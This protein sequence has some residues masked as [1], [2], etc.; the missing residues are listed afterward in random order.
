MALP[1]VL[2]KAKNMVSKGAQAAKTAGAVRSATSNSNDEEVKSF[3]GIFKTPIII[4][5]AI[6]GTIL[7]FILVVFIAIVSIPQ[8]LVGTIFGGGS[9]SSNINGGTNGNY[10]GDIGYIQ[11]AIDIANDDSHGYSQ[12]ARTAPDYDCSS[13]VY[14][15]LINAG[16]TTEQLGSYPFTT[17][18]MPTVLPQ[19]GFVRHSFVQ[20]ELQAG[21]ILW[22]SGHTAMYIGNDQIVHASGPEGGGLCGSA[23]DQTGKEIL[24]QGIAG[25]GPWTAY[26]RRA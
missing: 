24:V 26:Y 10:S 5:S 16:F 11:W 13:L 14:Y 17:A 18:T 21:D 1:T 19:A 4:V 22:R 12:C 15:S 6:A 20:S 2:L 25:S 23:G 7:A 3:F 9:I 8:I